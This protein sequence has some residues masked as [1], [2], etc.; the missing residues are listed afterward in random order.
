MLVVLAELCS[1]LYIHIVGYTHSQAM[2]LSGVVIKLSQS[3]SE[4]FLCFWKDS[5]KAFGHYLPGQIFNQIMQLTT[6]YKTSQL[7]TSRIT[8]LDHCI[9][10]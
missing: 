6:Y 8:I 3:A 9:H 1:C 10:K 4:S 2:D 7:T 5:G